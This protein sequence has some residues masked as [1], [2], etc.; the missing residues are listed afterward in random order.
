MSEVA[1]AL[2]ETLKSPNVLD[3]NYEGANI[4]DV[5]AKLAWAISRQAEGL[6]EMAGAI[7]KLAI[8]TNK[9]VK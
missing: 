3:A 5:I 1:E 9:E 4:V 2:R 8:E 6:N 7:N